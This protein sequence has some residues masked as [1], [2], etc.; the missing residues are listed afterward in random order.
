MAQK[1]PDP[2][3]RAFRRLLAGLPSRQFHPLMELLTEN[4]RSPV[5]GEYVPR[6]VMLYE[7]LQAVDVALKLAAEVS[8]LLRRLSRVAPKDRAT[9]ERIA[10]TQRNLQVKLSDEQLADR[11]GISVAVLR[12]RRYRA[13]K[14]RRDNA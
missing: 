2:A 4:L 11:F 14:R 13:R 8:R 9:W 7:K 3:E 6:L 1:P 5:R 10:Q 12:Q